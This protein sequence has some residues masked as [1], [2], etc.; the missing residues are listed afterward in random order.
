MTNFDH[1]WFF[2]LERLCRETTEDIEMQSSQEMVG[3]EEDYVEEQ[4]FRSLQENNTGFQRK[5]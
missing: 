1:L 4:V 5:H 3:W 2:I